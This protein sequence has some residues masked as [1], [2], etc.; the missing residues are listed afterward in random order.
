[1]GK[2]SNKQNKPSITVGI[3]QSNPPYNKIQHAKT[4]IK[5]YPP[6][7]KKIYNLFYKNKSTNTFQD[8]ID[9][10]QERKAQIEKKTELP[11][12]INDLGTMESN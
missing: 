6:L 12:K 5:R 2:L 8:Q 11:T 7:S 3:W 4:K 9:N 1:M 10:T